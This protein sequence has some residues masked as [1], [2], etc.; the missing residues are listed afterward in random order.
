[1]SVDL[2]FG[3]DA[4]NFEAGVALVQTA[5]GLKGEMRFS[6][7]VGGTYCLFEQLDVF[8]IKVFTNLD[9]QDDEPVSLA[10][11]EWL[12]AMTVSAEDKQSSIIRALEQNPD[13]FE[14]VHRKDYESEIAPNLVSE[15]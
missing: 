5:I 2:V 6:D 14:L 15:Q 7:H 12:I 1:M 11:K 4:D 9:V 10:A 13:K 8:E 3:I